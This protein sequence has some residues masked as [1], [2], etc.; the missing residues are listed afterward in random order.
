MFLY[1]S[2][3][4]TADTREGIKANIQAAREVAI[5][6]WNKGHV[7][8]CPH[9]NTSHFEDDCN[10]TYDDYIKGDLNVIARVDGM[11][12]IPGWEE[13]AG[14]KIEH[15][16]A[17][18]IGV[19]IWYA[20]NLPDIHPTE[21]NSPDQCKAFRET[22]GTMY[23]LHLSKNADYSP[24]NVAIPGEQGLATRLFDKTIRVMNLVGFKVYARTNDVPKTFWQKVLRFLQGRV[25]V[26][27][28]IIYTEP[29]NPQ[30]ETID[31]NLIDIDVYGVIFRL[32]RAGKWGH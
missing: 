8:Y 23:R 30:H 6:L 20:P 24:G 11:V 10:A 4:Y 22:V 19:P 28:D 31:E 25:V 16:Y 13:S 26:I 29:R 21:F 17:L 3:K 2:G 32:F 18:S 14:A 12:M 5:Q 27:D 15:D 9:L 1:T 7:V